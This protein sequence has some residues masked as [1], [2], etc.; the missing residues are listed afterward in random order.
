MQA[1]RLDQPQAPVAPLWVRFL[2]LVLLP[3]I[4]AGLYLEGQHYDT[5]LLRLEPGKVG[6]EQTA[7]ALA[8]A[9]LAGFEAIGQPRRY[10][11]ENLYEYING[12]AEYYIA[13][14][15]Q[16]LTV[17]EYGPAGAAQPNLV[18]NL[19]DLGKPLHAFGVLMNELSADA[20]PVEVGGMGFKAGQGVNFIVGPLYVQLNTFDSKE[21][22]LAAAQELAAA[23]KERL[24]KSEQLDLRFPE[25]GEVASTYFVK[26]D[27]R[28][29]GVLNNVLERTFRRGEGDVTAFLISGKAEDIQANVAKLKA[30]LDGEQIPVETRDLGGATLYVVKDRYEGE[31][32]FFPEK[33]RLL[34]VFAPPDEALLNL[35][36]GGR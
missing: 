6:A 36:R 2:L 18:V 21:A 23:L 19:Y 1:N 31:W 11:R 20:Q 12:H 34:G 4:A 30:F 35:V 3:L 10:T 17:A 5:G 28:G 33:E 22:P 27:Y 9:K 16:G 13:S 29:F 8:P 15:F 24:G 26:E 32:F 25:L 7:A 14:G